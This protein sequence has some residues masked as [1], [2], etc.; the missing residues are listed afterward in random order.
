MGEIPWAKLHG[1]STHFPIVLTFVA[2]VCDVVALVW[3]SKPA[4][5]GIGRVGAGAMIAAAL[6]SLVAVGSGLFLTRGEM[7]G[8][9]SLG[10]H[11]R[12]V[13]PAFGLIVGAATWRWVSRDRLTRKSYTLYLAVVLLGAILIGT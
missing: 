6:G 3:W 8:A 9:G 11:H 7:W 4:A 10:W 13:W 12:F 5:G 1:A 2:F